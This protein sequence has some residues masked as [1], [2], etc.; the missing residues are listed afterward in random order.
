MKTVY[1]VVIKQFEQN[2]LYR[3][4][5]DKQSAM[6]HAYNE[7]QRLERET[8]HQ[9]SDREEHGLAV[10]ARAATESHVL[11]EVPGYFIVV[12]VYAMPVR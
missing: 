6:H 8:G 2:N 9:L 12:E 7:I 5:E 4:I 10:I 1:L 11:G 3:I